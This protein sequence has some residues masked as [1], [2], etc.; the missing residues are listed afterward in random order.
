VVSDNNLDMESGEDS[1][2]ILE[3]FVCKELQFL[4]P[5]ISFHYFRLEDGMF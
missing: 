4:T 3:T 1:I 2:I 5:V